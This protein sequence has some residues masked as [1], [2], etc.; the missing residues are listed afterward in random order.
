M[1]E[2]GVYKEK[3]GFMFFLGSQFSDEGYVQLRPLQRALVGAICLLAEHFDEIALDLLDHRE[4]RMEFGRLP[5]RRAGHLT[6]RRKSKKSHHGA[7]QFLT[8]PILLI[9]WEFPDP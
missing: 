4:I 3:A 8:T 5:H 1:V 2:M 6:G 7:F 9:N